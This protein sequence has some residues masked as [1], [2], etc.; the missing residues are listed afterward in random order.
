[1]TRGDRDTSYKLV[2]DTGR[3]ECRRKID[4]QMEKEG[5]RPETWSGGGGRGGEGGLFG[6]KQGKK[7]IH[8]SYRVIAC[9]H[10][11]SYTQIVLPW[12]LGHFQFRTG[13][14]DIVR[15]GAVT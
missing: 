13:S 9:Q 5:R 12:N 8:S 2:Q 4:N 1:M 7:Q 11:A 10:P 6:S 15:T 3:R 14:R